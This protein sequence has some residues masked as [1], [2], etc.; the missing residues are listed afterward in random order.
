MKKKLHK[1][2]ALTVLAGLLA[3]SMVHA[4]PALTDRES[5]NQVA[6]L[7]SL[8]QGYFGGTVTVKDIRGLGDTGIGTFEGLNGEMI[9]LDGTVYQALGSGKVVVAD[10]KT[11]VPY[12]TVTYFD[13]D[14]SLDL[15]DVQNKETLEKLLNEEVNK[16]GK[17]SFYMVK[18]HT[19]FSSILFRSEYGSQK[20]YPTLVEALK[21][22]QTEFTEKNC[23]GTLVGLYCPAYMGEL[24]SPGWH[25]HFI[26]DDKKK[27]GHILELAFKKGTIELDKT[28]KFTM[29]LHDDQVFHKLNLAKDMSADIQ[30]AERDTQSTMKTKGK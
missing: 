24:N 26:S 16:C 12:G 21:G 6:L 13:N 14:L 8:A 18:L 23:K 10:D 7:Q 25:F 3:G 30:S 2:L 17:N 29:V 4:S 28:D 22:K 1:K 5:L 27:G 9:V 19:E 11:L 15:K 20:P